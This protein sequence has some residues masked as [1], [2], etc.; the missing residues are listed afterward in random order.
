MVAKT[1]HQFHIR[2]RPDLMEELRARA[3]RAD[4]PVNYLVQK[5]IEAWLEGPEDE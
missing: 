4:R 1:V 5:A 2:I 3:E